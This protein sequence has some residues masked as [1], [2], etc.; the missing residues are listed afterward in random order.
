MKYIKLLAKYLLILL[1]FT[2][3][4]YLIGSMN[5]DSAVALSKA[6]YTIA[7]YVIP[8]VFVIWLISKKSGGK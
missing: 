1:A 2:I 5:G 7:F 8:L 6:V 4:S 3:L